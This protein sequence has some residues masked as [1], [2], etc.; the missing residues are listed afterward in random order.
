M[1]QN[2]KA[3]PAGDCIRCLNYV[4]QLAPD[5]RGRV[6]ECVSTLSSNDS[7]TTSDVPESEKH[8]CMWHGWEWMAW[9]GMNGMDENG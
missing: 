1:R 7:A 6:L 2:H 9:M 4:A 3:P 8:K 5:L